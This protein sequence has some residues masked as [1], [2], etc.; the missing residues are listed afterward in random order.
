MRIVY[1]ILLLVLAIVFYLSWIPDPNLKHVSFIPSW[2]S[3]W[4]DSDGFGNVRTAIPFIILGLCAG[5]LPVVGAKELVVRWL[6]AWAVLIG[7]AVI[8]ELGQLF[9]PNRQFGWADISWGA[10]GALLGLS[11]AAIVKERFPK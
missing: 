4:A 9:L 2:L 8:A 3:T 5:L 11:V 6:I 7:V 10:V 1:L